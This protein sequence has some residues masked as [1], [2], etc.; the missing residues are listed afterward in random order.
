M[1]PLQIYRMTTRSRNHQRHLSEITS[2]T[3]KRPPIGGLFVTRQEF[4]DARVIS[5]VGRH[6]LIGLEAPR[7]IPHPEPGLTQH[8]ASHMT[9]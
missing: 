8:P 4:H 5:V 2:N 1:N 7:E 3:G 9:P 6:H